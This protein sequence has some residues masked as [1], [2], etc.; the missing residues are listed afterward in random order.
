MSC[1]DFH[2]PAWRRGSD[3]CFRVGPLEDDGDSFLLIWLEN[4]L[5]GYSVLQRPQLNLCWRASIRHVV[6]WQN[7]WEL[8]FPAETQ[9]VWHS[10]RAGVTCF[11]DH[12]DWK[13]G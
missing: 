6:F 10:E 2:G 11:G 13:T 3:D 5:V 12:A 8:S 7:R 1:C 9:I 4:I